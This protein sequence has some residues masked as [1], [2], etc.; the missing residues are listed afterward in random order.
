MA[1][2]IPK[3]RARQPGEQD[4]VFCPLCGRTYRDRSVHKVAGVTVESVPYFDSIEWDPEKPLGVT[5]RIGGRA[6]IET[7]GYFQPADR[8]ELFAPLKARLLTVLGQ[9]VKR[10]WLTREEI[11]S[12]IK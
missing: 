4:S 7:V 3:A 1:K 2:R 8:P 9:W 10:G 11:R 6:Q 12:V 5:Q